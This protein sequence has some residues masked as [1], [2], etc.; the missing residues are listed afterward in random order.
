VPERE[1][2]TTVSSFALTIRSLAKDALLG[3]CQGVVVAAVASVALGLD[4]AAWL[5]VTGL[6]ALAGAVFAVV[7][8][9]LA[10]AFGAVGRL[11]AVC[12]AVIGLAVGLASTVPPIFQSLATFFPT[13]PALDMLRAVPAGDPGGIW[14]GIVG[15]LLFAVLGVALVFAGVAARRGMRLGDLLPSRA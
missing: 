14:A 13:T 9:G 1:L 5:T 10:A 8:R 12:V 11:I 4:P 2:L 6:S 15:C 7:N 3:L